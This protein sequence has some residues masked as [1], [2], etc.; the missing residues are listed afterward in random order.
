MLQ[1]NQKMPLLCQPVIFRPF[2]QTGKM[3]GNIQML[4]T[5]IGAAA[6]IDTFACFVLSRV[7]FVGIF[8]LRQISEDPCIV[9]NFDEAGNRQFHG[10]GGK[11][12]SA[13]GT[14]HQRDLVQK[15]SE[16]SECF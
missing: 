11:T 6:A 8:D 16:P 4:G 1:K 7:H 15:C 12:I 9:K 3:E 14:F 5:N 10:A 13:P 2:R